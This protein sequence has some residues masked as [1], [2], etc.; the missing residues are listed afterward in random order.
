MLLGRR[1]VF[2]A[3][4]AAGLCLSTVSPVAAADPLLPTAPAPQ[5]GVPA[6]PPPKAYI[7]VDQATGRVLAASNDRQP[8]PPASLTKVITALAAVAALPPTAKVPVS[9]R[10]AAMPAHK[11]NMKP[12]TPWP[13]ADTLD[14]LLLSSANDAA[15]A[16]AERVS[17]SL[18]NFQTHLDLLAGQLKMADSP[19]LQD[20]AGLDDYSSVRGGNLVSARDLAIATRALLANPRLAPIV[21]TPVARFTD[22]Q[23]IPHKLTNHNKMMFRYFG[24]IGV[25]TG[26]TKKSGRGLIAAATRNGRTSIAVIMNVADTYGWATGLLDASFASALPATADRLPAIPSSV[27]LTSETTTLSRASR[28]DATLPK[29]TVDATQPNVTTKG[30]VTLVALPAAQSSG[31]VPPLLGVLLG[32]LATFGAL[33][34]G[35]RARVLVKRRKRRRK[36]T[37]SNASIKHHPR[38]RRNPT[39][40]V[41]HEPDQK[42]RGRF[43]DVTRDKKP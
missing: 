27:K 13:L 17:G 20:P 28:S 33:I 26:F 23:G 30:D 8:L 36:R 34:T 6:G 9:E 5:V 22:P 11:L 35:L 32:M 39:L 1:A 10:A 43:H 41:N 24:T 19:V 29:R 7:V 12:G 40:T 42:M 16:L 31:G 21:A 14:A 25:K 38:R 37:R 15:A 2:V 4:I 18:E 3:S